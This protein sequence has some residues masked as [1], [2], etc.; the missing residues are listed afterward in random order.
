[1]LRP[2]RTFVFSL[3]VLVTAFLAG[4]VAAETLATRPLTTQGPQPTGAEP[5]PEALEALGGDDKPIFE[6]G[7]PVANPV[8]TPLEPIGRRDGAEF[9][10]APNSPTIT[11][12]GGAVQPFGHNGDPQQWVNILG[13]VTGPRPISSLTY[14]LNGGPPQPLNRGPDQRRLTQPGDFIIEI[15]YTSLHDGANQVA[16]T[17][18][19]GVSTPTVANVT[20]NYH[21]GS[22]FC[23]PGVYTYDWHTAGKISDHGQVVTGQWALNQAA[24]IVKPVLLAYDRL[25][26][27][28]DL[29]WRDYTVTVPITINAIDEGGF[30]APSNGPGV[31]VLVRWQ[32]HYEL[33]NIFPRV[34][35]RRLGALA[36]HRWARTGSVISSGYELLGHGGNQLA[37]DARS[38][39]FGETYIFKVNIQSN[40]PN[41]PATYRFKSWNA[42]GPEPATWN[43][44]E[45]GRS[46]EP[47]SGSILLLAHHVDAEFGTVTVQLNSTQPLLVNNT[48][49]GQG[50]I[51]READQNPNLTENLIGTDYSSFTLEVNTVGNGQVTADPQKP[52]YLC[53]EEVVLTAVPD[54]GW[55]FARWSGDL[56]GTNPVASLTVDGHQAVTATFVP[57]VARYYLPAVLD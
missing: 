31:G 47:E 5:D 53:G 25:L 36:W 29:T 26:A 14:S 4:S 56:V 9:Q 6:G 11:V 16:I 23:S 3:L 21:G 19:D 50:T 37:S 2:V 55:F 42:G 24:G 45:R 57:E 40:G 49:N 52:A 22:T 34:G 41:Q 46:G 32:G 54:P 33:N 39:T 51:I 20:I 12:W 1:M 35:W 38:V 18:A 10:A 27:I 8:F 17:A 15:D 30:P 43:F 13:R 7:A 48:G 44:E 28:G